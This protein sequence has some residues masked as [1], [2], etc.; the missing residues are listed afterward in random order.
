MS[1][2]LTVRFAK[3]F[4]G[5]SW[6]FSS[7]YLLMWTIFFKRPSWL[8][9]CSIS[10]LDAID[11][12]KLKR[13]GHASKDCKQTFM[14]QLICY[15][16]V[17][18]LFGLEKWVIEKSISSVSLSLISLRTLTS[19]VYWTCT[20]FLIAWGPFLF[21]FPYMSIEA[22]SIESQ[23]FPSFSG[24]KGRLTAASVLVSSFDSSCWPS[25]SASVS[26]FY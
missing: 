3:G 25:P 12:S 1:S 8:S 18:P 4:F 20:V 13:A 5:S 16:F 6:F 19:S 15:A 26:G 7:K 9:D 24:S 21:L 2:E 10:E 14:K 23:L 11:W 17:K 22:R